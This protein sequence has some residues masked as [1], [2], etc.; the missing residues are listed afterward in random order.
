MLGFTPLLLLSWSAVLLVH[1]P[2]HLFHCSTVQSS[3]GATGSSTAS[4]KGGMADLR[5]DSVRTVRRGSL[6]WLQFP[7]LSLLDGLL[8]GISLR[9]GDDEVREFNLADH[10]GHGKA[11]ATRN[12][13]RWCNA[14]GANFAR[15]TCPRQVHSPEVVRVAGELAGQGRD[16]NTGA[17]AECDAVFTDLLDVPLMVLS[18]D[19]A[20]LIV[21]DPDTPAVG[22]AHAGWR[23]TVSGIAARLV[24][25]MQREFRS[26]PARYRAG[27]SPTA[28]PDRY[29]VGGDV[30]SLAVKHLQS[31]DRFFRQT[32][33]GRCFDLPK[34]NHFQLT[35]AGLNAENIEVAGICTIAQAAQ[36]YSYRRQRHGAGRFGLLGSLR[37]CGR[38]PDR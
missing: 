27:V 12:R 25:A 20:L 6:R 7:Q 35:Q 11:D 8:H 2:A 28:G 38:K 10:A 33:H 18:A 32:A 36:F 17:I 3:P 26:D 23:G 31:A 5:F 21:F 15:L 19:C 13:R 24:E 16:G 4:V 22:L 14:I 1:S 29:E 30:Y 34:A 9:D 37:S